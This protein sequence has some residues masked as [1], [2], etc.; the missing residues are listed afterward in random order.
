MA[1]YTPQFQ[2][3]NGLSA[4]TLY[5]SSGATFAIGVNVNSLVTTN[6]VTFG[7]G[8]TFM[9]FVPNTAAN[10]GGL[11]LRDGILQVAGSQLGSGFGNFYYNVNTEKHYVYGYQ[12]ISNTNDY[13]KTNTPLTILGGTGQTVPLFSVKR[14]ATAVSY[15]DQNGILV[16]ASG[17]SASGGA[18]F[19]GQVN[20]TTFKANTVG[21]SEGGQID[22]GLAATGTSLSTGVSIDIYQNKLRFFETGGN[23][24]GAYLDLTNL[25]SGVGTDLA[26]RATTSPIGITSASNLYAITYP[27]GITSNRSD[28]TAWY[29][30]FVETSI[31]GAGRAVRANRTYFRI[32]NVQKDTAIKSV[33]ITSAN[34]GVTGNC[35]FSI[36][37][38]DPDSG[39]PNT[40]LYL[41]ASTV[42]GSGYNTTTVTNA[43]GLV[44]VPSGKWWLAVTFDSAPTIFCG[45]AYYYNAYLGAPD[46]YSGIRFQGAIADTSTYT[47]PSAIPASGVTFGFIEYTAGQNY[48]EGA[49]G[50]EWTPV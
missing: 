6:G 7:S 16:A 27:D 46:Y 24:R 23:N 42:V 48:F 3:V 50:L 9:Q 8:T 35:Y 38:C 41:S 28:R 49:I 43:S 34:T 47:V 17:L 22:F 39:F 25:P 20:V 21:G 15:V 37:S 32:Q 44:T 1:D 45:S 31:D 12:E 4:G 19:A 2:A 18:T 13:Q 30:S 36:W 26:N 5:V 33:R 14:G 10:G 40:R 11:W 29:R